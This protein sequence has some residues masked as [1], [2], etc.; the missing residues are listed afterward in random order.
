MSILLE[1]IQTISKYLFFLCLVVIIVVS[2]LPKFNVNSYDV[3]SEGFSIRLDYLLHF[4]AY[5][6][7]SA[8]FLLWKEENPLLSVIIIL[9]IGAFVAFMTEFQ[10]IYIPGRAYN[11][12]DMYYNVSG[13]GVG[14]LI[15][16]AVRYTMLD[17]GDVT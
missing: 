12:V 13:V 6:A 1:N 8:F 7:L 4:L 14:I 16:L 3:G 10:Q 11:P 2:A 5:L 17:R 9:A 15:A